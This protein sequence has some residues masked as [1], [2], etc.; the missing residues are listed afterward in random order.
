LR[1]PAKLCRFRP[2]NVGIYK[3]ADELASL[4]L[5]ERIAQGYSAWTLSTERSALRMFFQDRTLTDGID[6]PKR[7]RENIVRSRHPVA[8]DTHINL[9]N[10]RHVIDFCLACGLRREELR[11][12]YVREVYPRRSDGH[13]VVFVR[14]GKGGKDREV[15]VFPGREQNVLS[16]IEHRDPDEHVFG[17]ISGFLDII[18][19]PK[20]RAGVV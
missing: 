3:Q 12:L 13:L 2:L 1:R 15:P 11:D 10:W 9:D 18:A 5:L 20:V 4:Y 14:H 8:R 7:K 19:T 16:Q 17:R 6:L